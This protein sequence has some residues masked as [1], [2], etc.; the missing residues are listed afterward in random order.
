VFEVVTGVTKVILVI[1]LA[2][3]LVHRP[4]AYQRGLRRL[5]PAEHEEAFDETWSRVHDAL[6]RWVGGILVAMLIMGVLTGVGL[7]A[8]GM[9]DWLLLAFLTFLGTFVP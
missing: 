8:I 4:D 2:A 5:V 7:L 1:V 6:R 3:F 9:D